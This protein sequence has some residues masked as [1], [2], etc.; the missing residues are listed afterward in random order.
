MNSNLPIDSAPMIFSL[1]DFNDTSILLNG[2]GFNQDHW[3]WFGN[4]PSPK[5]TVLSNSRI[6][7]EKC[8]STQRED[9]GSVESPVVPILIARSDGIVFSSNFFFFLGNKFL[10]SAMKYNS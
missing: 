5:T 10:D 2:Y 7:V 4:I 3:I 6:I 9:D 8:L 1:H